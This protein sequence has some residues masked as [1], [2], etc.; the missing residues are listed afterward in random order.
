MIHWTAWEHNCSLFLC[1]I[2]HQHRQKWPVSHWG[3]G[4]WHILWKALGHTQNAASGLGRAR[5]SWA[6][7]HAVPCGARHLFPFPSM[8]TMLTICFFSQAMQFGTEDN[9]TV[10]IVP[11]GAWGKYKNGEIN[12]SFSRSF[13]SSGRWAWRPATAIF[14]CHNL[15]T[16]CYR[17]TH[18]SVH[19]LTRCLVHLFCSQCYRRCHCSLGA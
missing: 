5:K 3:S 9:S 19:R 11:F 15:D 10:V 7:G 2:R 6:S 1:W 4:W 8:T 17:R 14:S 16:V 12:F 13:A 18:P